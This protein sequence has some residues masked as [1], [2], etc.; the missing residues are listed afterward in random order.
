[1]L[2]DRREVILKGK[3]KGIGSEEA[4]REQGIQEQRVPGGGNSRGRGT[5]RG[6]LLGCV[7]GG[8]VRREEV[9]AGQAGS[10]VRSKDP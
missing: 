8:G 3:F 9:G 5:E 4:A 1:M 6:G 10:G 2:R 7:C